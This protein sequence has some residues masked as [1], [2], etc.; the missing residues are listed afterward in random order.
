MWVGIRD[1]MCLLVG[2]VYWECHLDREKETVLS[3]R[4]GEGMGI[5]IR[6]ER[7]NGDCNSI[8]GRNGDCNSIGGRNGDL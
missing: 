5:V 2:E 8:G 6:L 4:L 3:Y 7:R 1:G